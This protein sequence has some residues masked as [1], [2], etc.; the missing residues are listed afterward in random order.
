MES[1]QI[2]LC[3]LVAVILLLAGYRLRPLAVDRIS[4]RQFVD[5]FKLSGVPPPVPLPE[6]N[7]DKAKARPYRPFRWSYHQTMSLKK[8]DPDYFVEL[9]STYRERIAQRKALYKEHGKKIIDALP[10]SELA[11]REL[12]EMVVQFLCAR[13]PNQFQLDRRSGLLHNRILNTSYK[14]DEEDPLVVLNENVPEDYLLTLPDPKT[15][16]YTMVA[17]VCCSALGWNVSTKIGKPLKDIHDVVPDYKEKMEFSMDRF[18]SKMPSDKPIQRGSWG[19]EIGQPLYLQPDD[20]HF[21]LRN[22]Q[23]PNLRLEDIFLRV[24]WQTLRRL[25]RSGSIVFNFKALFTPFTSFQNEPYIPH[26]ALKV[27]KEGK[28]SILE[29]KGTWHVEHKVIPAL[30]EWSREQEEKGWVPKNWEVRT[31]DEDPYFPGWEETM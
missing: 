26:I 19:L 7:V 29:Y 25:P 6:F 30:E 3:S 23:D 15:G 13:Y 1:P 14:L 27:L 4:R 10:G 17:G 8:M 12:M 21:A 2:A 31:L 18:F 5:Y 24:D 16:L 20:P 28:R 11:C 22:K 9:E